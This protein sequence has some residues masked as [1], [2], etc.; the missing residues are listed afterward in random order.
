M[1]P[2]NLGYTL[3]GASMLGVG[4]F[5][6]NAGS[7]LEANAGAALAF[8]NTMLATAAAILAWAL[9][10]KL[11]KGKS[12]ALG[13]ASGAVAGL[14]GI[15]PAC[16]TVGP[17]G[18][19]AIGA[20]AAFICV[21]GVPGLKK[22]LGADDSLDVFGVHGIGGIVGSVL[23]AFTMMPALGGPG[24]PASYDAGAQL[25]IQLKSVGVAIAWSAIGSA[26]AFSIAKAVT[27]L[28]VSTDTERE[29]LDLGEHGERA[30]NY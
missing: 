5:G 25:M 19:I 18:A 12:S 30:Y 10:E 8:L 4:W 23:T 28:R 22:M 2:H 6:F 21:W 11:F 29:G 17:F 13:V 1:P 24:D 14:V 20:I 3:I 27:G 15:T 7:N 16:G 9:A 26:I